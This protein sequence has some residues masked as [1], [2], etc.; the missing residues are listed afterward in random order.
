MDVS[1]EISDVTTKPNCCDLANILAPTAA[2]GSAD[3]GVVVVV[4]LLIIM[5]TIMI[6]VIII[7]LGVRAQR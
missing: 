5:I 1:R 3:E 7:K 4:L 6:L 2:Q